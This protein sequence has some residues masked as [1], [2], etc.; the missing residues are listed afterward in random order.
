MGEI[1]AC[2]QVSK[3]WKREIDAFSLAWWK[4]ALTRMIKTNDFF[5][6]VRRWHHWKGIYDHLLEQRNKTKIVKFSGLVLDYLKKAEQ[7]NE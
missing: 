7:K 2:R 1:L 4:K 6:G 5:F 3:S